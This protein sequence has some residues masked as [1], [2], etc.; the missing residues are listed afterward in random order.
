ML[1]KELWG[2]HITLW[3]TLCFESNPHHCHSLLVRS[4][5]VHV[6][7]AHSN[8]AATLAGLAF[9]SAI[10]KN[11]CPTAAYKTELFARR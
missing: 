3:A 7:S 2:A 5:T 9:C 1:T 8:L 4:P 6:L 11:V 10:N